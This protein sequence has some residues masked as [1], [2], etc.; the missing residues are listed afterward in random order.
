MQHYVAIVEDTGPDAAIGVWFPDLPGCFSAGDTMD[1]AVANAPEA[2]AAYAEALAAD[3]RQLPLPRTLVE[4][5]RD[6][7]FAAD[8]QG[9][10]VA[11]V[12]APERVPAE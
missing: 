12:T 8:V 2:V 3:G 6:P 10:M 7:T 5:K 4:L 1:E 9:N 11:L